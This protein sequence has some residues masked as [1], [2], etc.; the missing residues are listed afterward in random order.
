MMI[1]AFVIP[2]A[3]PVAGLGLLLILA[4]LEAFL[5]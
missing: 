1:T 2:I 5:L 3:I 4:W